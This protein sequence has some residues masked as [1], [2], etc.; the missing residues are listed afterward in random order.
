MANWAS[1]LQ[2]FAI[3]GVIGWPL[4]AGVL[5]ILWS[6]ARAASHARRA[7]ALDAGLKGLYGEIESRPPP[8]RLSRVIDAL[9]EAEELQPRPTQPGRRRRAANA[10]RS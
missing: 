3:A 8:A 4:A 10:A 6:R 5:V 2:M 9:E 7:A 1:P